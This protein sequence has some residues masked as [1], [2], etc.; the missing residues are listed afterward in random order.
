MKPVY[1]IEIAEGEV[2]GF[3]VAPQGSQWVWMRFSSVLLVVKGQ[4]QLGVRRNLRG[5]PFFAAVDYELSVWSLTSTED[6][7]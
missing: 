7:G 4:R 2:E 5:V 6:C 3:V 1:C